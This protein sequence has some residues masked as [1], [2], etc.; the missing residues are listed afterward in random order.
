MSIDKPRELTAH[1]LNGEA[2]VYT[3]Q[4]SKN[5][6]KENRGS[7]EYQRNQTRYPRAWGFAEDKIKTYE[8]S[9]LTGSA[10]EH[11]PAFQ[12]VI[13][14]MK[15]ERITAVFASDQSR[16]GRNAV[17]WFEFLNLCRIHEVVPVI[18]G[19][20]IK[21]GDGG[22]GFSSRVM[23]LV[24][25]YDL[26]KRRGHI[27]RGIAGRL[28]DRKAVSNPP[29][30]YV[31]LKNEKKGEWAFDPN[32]TVQAAIAAVFRL[33]PEER[34]CARTV[35]RLIAEGMKIPAS[36]PGVA[37]YWV[38]PNTS[39]VARILNNPAYCGDYVYRRRVGDAKRGKNR[40]GQLRVRVAAPE[41]MVTIPGHHPAYV[42]RETWEDGQRIL[43]LNAPSKE[44]RNLGPGSALLQGVLTC[45]R[46]SNRSMSVDYK[47]C[48]RDGRN[49]AHYY[50]C[51]GTYE[52]GG[53]QCGALPGRP[54]DIAVA[55]AVFAR[56][57]PLSL[58]ELQAQWKQVEEN[59]RGGHRARDL[60]VEQA[61]R[62]AQDMRKRYMQVNPELRELAE[63]V[64]RE[65]N[66]ALVALKRAQTAAT[67]PATEESFFTD[68]TFEELVELCQDLPALFYAATTL[69]RDRK[70]VIRTTAETVEVTGRTEETISA[71]IHWADGSEPTL[72]EA[73]LHRFVHRLIRELAEQGLSNPAIAT[74]VNE[75]GFVTS[76][77]NPWTRETVWVARFGNGSRRRS[78]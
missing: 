34:S 48:L 61:R 43:A 78:A 46:H 58:E 69:D 31:S 37:L 13:T 71:V 2:A 9:G 62:H 55:R 6:E 11:R 24:D 52:Q 77:G 40:Y 19:R 26:E 65:Y 33:F 66:E 14:G 73:H 56:L 10:S 68:D 67:S 35:R 23:A 3:R 42:S 21:L 74:R 41:E 47:E 25:E 54:L 59:D 60:A 30:G 44:R 16:L 32:P 72:V 75:M 57:T 50:H 5:Q 18:D 38:E 22:D 17:E 36:K 28:G 8:D 76:R 63:E 27:L 70:E 1:H 51:L 53:K 39:A 15:A 49:G 64:E 29:T 7:L 45:G 12:E 20:I 4:S